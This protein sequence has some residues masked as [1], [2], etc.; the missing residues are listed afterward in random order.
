MPVVLFR[1]WLPRTSFMWVTGAQ[2]WTARYLRYAHAKISTF[3][4]L[5]AHL[6]NIE[7]LIIPFLQVLVNCLR[8]YLRRPETDEDSYW[9][10]FCGGSFRVPAYEASLLHCNFCCKQNKIWHMCSQ[11]AL[12][13]GRLMQLW[14]VV[15]HLAPGSFSSPIPLVS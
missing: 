9:W 14:S 5:L 10:L 1:A 11:N 7:L 3:S 13:L 4:N 15:G 6:S 2:N 12:K 8:Y